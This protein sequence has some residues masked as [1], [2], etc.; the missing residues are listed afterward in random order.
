MQ[1][2]LQF[3]VDHA[4]HG[5]DRSCITRSCSLSQPE[6]NAASRTLPLA[7]AVEGQVRLSQFPSGSRTSREESEPTLSLQSL[8]AGR[9]NP[10]PGCSPSR[11]AGTEP[12]GFVRKLCGNS[13]PD[14][15][16]S[17]V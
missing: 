9:I 8:A 16:D 2:I 12:H 4:G 1:Q 11:K 7:T 5:D 10:D 13:P 17:S 14:G 15:L 6:Q 3:P